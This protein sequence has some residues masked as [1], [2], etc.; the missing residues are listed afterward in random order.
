MLTLGGPTR[1]HLVLALDRLLDHALCK[2]T[3]AT[4]RVIECKSI[5]LYPPPRR[6]TRE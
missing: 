6:D 4:A 1:V 5:L 3:T 2:A